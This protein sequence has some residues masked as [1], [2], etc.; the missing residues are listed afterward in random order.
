MIKKIITS[1]FIFLS[2]LYVPILI[3]NASAQT[4]VEMGSDA[5]LANQQDERLEGTIRTISEEKQ[6]QVMDRSQ[7]YQKLG[8]EVTTGSL[9]G[10]TV[11]VE[12]G[13]LPSSNVVHYRVGDEVI[14]SFSKSPDGQ[15]LIMITDFIRR[16]SLLWLLIIFVGITVLVGRLKGI[17]S[18]FGMTVSFLVIFLFILPQIL[19]GRD[20]VFITIIGSLV[21]IPFSFYLSHGL[22]KKTT[23][24][25]IGTV[26]ALIVTGI[27][28]SIFVEA[29]KLSG[30]VSEEAGFLQAAQ[31]SLI[32][33]KGL[34][35]SGIIIGVLG[36][37][38]DVTISQSAMV[39]EMKSLN[40]KMSAGE[41]YRSAMAVGR[42]H[43]AS[44]VNT[45][46]L[47]YAGASLPLLLL[48]IN[49]THSFSE[50]INYEIIATEI[51]R[52]LVG[53]IGLVLAVPLTT[54]IAAVAE[55]GN[56]RKQ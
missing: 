3:P 48:F 10:Q 6:I 47:V 22:N 46:V 33:I 43:I 26:I 11:T 8:V 30:F 28:A 31:G 23:V 19:A 15:S 41:L 14:L 45:L 49:S 56:I 42:D 7:L 4:E 54:I 2:L 53:S 1:I 18:I 55:E 36:V 20:P 13:D 32:N 27:L 21:I 44:M 24:A 35:L 51:I 40:P 16:G 29:G 37:L 25:I 12:N 5:Q 9:K 52:T 38:D 34:I 17:T 39:R 50:V